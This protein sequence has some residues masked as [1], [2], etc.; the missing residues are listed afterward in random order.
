MSTRNLWVKVTRS[1]GKLK[2]LTQKLVDA[3]MEC[4]YVYEDGSIY[5]F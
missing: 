5:C 1:V 3:T 4:I 2:A